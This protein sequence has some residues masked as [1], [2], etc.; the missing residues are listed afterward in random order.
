[1]IRR[2]MT[3]K[4]VTCPVVKATAAQGQQGAHA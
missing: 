1:M 2:R 3:I 4:K